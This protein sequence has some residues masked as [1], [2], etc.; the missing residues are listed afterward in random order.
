M[1]THAH[2][3]TPIQPGSAHLVVWSGQLLQHGVVHAL[4]VWA[5]TDGQ[6][7]IAPP[8]GVTAIDHEFG[9]TRLNVLDDFTSHPFAALK[10]EHRPMHT[11]KQFH[12]FNRC[13]GDP[14]LIH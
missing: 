14:P 10:P 3:K 5:V 2:E 1:I 7:L 11:R 6:A 9:A 12:A 13:F 4:P 8:Y